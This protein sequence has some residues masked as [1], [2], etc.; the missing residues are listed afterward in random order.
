MTTARRLVTADWVLPVASP[1]IAQGAV[2]LEGARIAWVGPAAHAP[3][4]PATVETTALGAAILT[5]GLVNAHTHLEL[6]AL[7]GFLEGL[8]FDTWLRTLT[9]VRRDLLTTDDLLDSCRLGIAEGLAHGITTYADT[10]DSGLPLVAMRELGVRGIGYLEVFGPDPS[11]AQD[12]VA[13]LAARARTAREA[14]TPRVRTGLSPHAPYTVSAPLFREVAEL[15]RRERYPLAVHIAESAAESAFVAEGRG[16]FAEGLAARGIAVAPQARSPIAL[17]EQC[18]VLAAQ[19]LLIHAIRADDDD[20]ARVAAHGA[21]IVHCP[22]SNAKLGHGVAPLDRFLAHGVATGLGSDSVASNDRMHLLE[23]ARQAVLAHA[24]RSGQPDSLTAHEALRLAT[25]GGAQALRLADG[26]GTLTPGA[27]ADLAA[28]AL[29]SPH[30]AAANDAV[31]SFAAIGAVYDPAVTL[32][33]VLA[34]A[35]RAIWVAVDGEVRVAGGRV[36]DADPAWHQRLGKV[37][38]RLRQWRAAPPS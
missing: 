13:A 11:Q 28:F 15:A 16:R 25:A 38:T 36:L 32:V 19:P 22:I 2:L 26:L 35:A 8:P 33:H 29:S 30:G 18:G 20:L 6:T 12:A 1:P 27:P 24:V 21:T 14:D 37:A 17:L 23:E 3:V 5:P 10:T 7:R 34:G 9:V 31:S 4:A